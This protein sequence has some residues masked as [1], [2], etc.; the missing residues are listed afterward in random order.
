MPGSGAFGHAAPEHRNAAEQ[1]VDALVQLAQELRQVGDEVLHLRCDRGYDEKD[2]A[3][4][5]ADR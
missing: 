4:E 5:R 1:A 3:D 2:D